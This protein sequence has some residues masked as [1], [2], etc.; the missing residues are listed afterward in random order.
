MAEPSAK[1]GAAITL[2]GLAIAA[3]GIVIVQITPAGGV[4]AELAWI[5]HLLVYDAGP[6]VA[7]FGVGWL[8]SGLHPLR[9]YYLYSG[10]AAVYL[11]FTAFALSTFSN[12][13]NLPTA[14]AILLTLIYSAGPSMLLSAALAGVAVNRRVRKAGIKPSPNPH[15]NILDFFVMIALYI[16]LLPALGSPLFYLRY[17]LPVAV[18]FL[19]WHTAA[20]RLALWLLSR[21]K[22]EIVLAE[23]PKAEET[24]LFNVLSRSYIPMAFGLGVVTT[25]ASVLDLLNISLFRGDPFSATADAAFLAAVATAAGSLYVGPVAW[26]FEDSGIRLYDRVRRI[27]RPPSIH[28]LADEM[29]EIYTF[30][31]SPIALTF[32]LA[33]GDLALALI[34]LGLTLHLLLT[35]S[36]TATYLYMTFSAKKHLETMVRSLQAR[37]L[38]RPFLG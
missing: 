20:P 15:E 7:S 22:T 24:T 19:V 12:V 14:A 25:V 3:A 26:L 10:V 37:S 16:P 33:D 32:A 29:V 35:I 13:E 30:I 17:L 34:L 21:R 2:T 11:S 18:T 27:M 4:S 8:V 23:P 9:K 1:T 5:S 28:S 36:F 6:A 38:A 31:F